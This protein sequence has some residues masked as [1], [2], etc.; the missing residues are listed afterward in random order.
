MP[1]PSLISPVKP[2]RATNPFRKG[3]LCQPG[4]STRSLEGPLEVTGARHRGV[5]CNKTLGQ[6]QSPF[7][8]ELRDQRLYDFTGRNS[9]C[10]PLTC[11]G[12]QR[13]LSER[14]PARSEDRYPE[15]ESPTG[16]LAPVPL[17]Q[18]IFSA[19]EVSFVSNTFG[20]GIQTSGNL[21]LLFFLSAQLKDAFYNLVFSSP[22]GAYIPS[23]H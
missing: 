3:W 23:Q 8:L 17:F 4:L 22:K 14:S 1:F 13:S 19:A 21:A 2:A 10:A 18:N 11:L 15:T 12:V 9:R 7:S 16:R 6:A 5:I 20:F